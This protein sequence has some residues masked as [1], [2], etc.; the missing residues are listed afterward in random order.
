MFTS[1]ENKNVFVLTISCLAG[2][3]LVGLVVTGTVAA[4]EEL[5]TTI[6]APDQATTGE[7]ISVS[8]SISVPELLRDYEKEMTVTLYVDGEEVDSRTVTVTDGETTQVDFSHTFSNSGSKTLRVETE[9]TMGQQSYSGSASKSVEV[10]EPSVSTEVPESIST[11]T[12]ELEATTREGAAFAVPESLEDEVDQYRDDSTQSLNGQAFVLAQQE[13]LYIVFT[14]EEPTKG[15]ATVEGATLE[16]DISS[17]NLTFGVIAATSVSFNTAGTETTVQEVADNSREYRQELVRINSHYRRVSTLTDPDT[18]DDVTLAST[19]GIL[20][21]DPATA[22]S[23]FENAG[24]DA[25]AI[26]NNSSPE[27][28]DATLDDPRGPHLHTFSFETKF[29]ADADATVDAVVLDPNSAAQEFVKEYDQAGIAHAEDGEPILYVVGEDFEPRS[30]ND[31]SS[32]KSQAESLDGQVVETNVRLYQ[33]KISVQESLEHNTGCE[34]D[35]LKI[36]TP[37]GSACINVAQDNLLHAGTAWNTV[38]QSREDVLIVMGVSSRHQDSPEE[39]EEGQYRIQGEVVS[40]DRINESLPEGSVLVIY[41]LERTGNIDYEAVSE[42]SRAIV[43]TQS[44]RMSTLLRQQVGGKD[45]QLAT[46]STRQTVEAVA[47]GEPVTVTI[48]DKGQGSIAVQR[49]NVT[50]SREL[51]NLQIDSSRVSSVPERVGQPPGQ[52]LR[53]LNISTSAADSDISSATFQVRIYKS[54]VPDGAE[55][56]VSR[57]HSGEWSALNTTIVAETDASVTIEV[58]TPGFSYFSVGTEGG[59]EGDTATTQSV[60]DNQTTQA[61]TEAQGPGFTVLTV[62]LSLIVLIVLRFK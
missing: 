50:S 41:Q 43:E 40:T 30:M 56:T 28:I 49:I 12:P 55:L 19:A 4:Q 34:E 39:F 32:I 48:P 22:T 2:I 25:R 31:V 17:G 62:L 1:G 37:Q 51:Q 14:N 36:Q 13:G 38:P 5:T 27:Q 18:G 60:Q 52:S 58:T 53:L 6:D 54:A 61:A 29:W 42:E 59:T 16:R 9:V 23:L 35:L 45:V 10:V 11:V 20:V 15:T 8:S 21:D 46:G 44:D 33:E 3:V 47:A 57:Y 24:T 26:S 7:A